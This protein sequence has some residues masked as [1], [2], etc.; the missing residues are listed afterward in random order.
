MASDKSQGRV[1]IVL[2]GSKKMANNTVLAEVLE[3][4]KQAH[5]EQADS[6]TRRQAKE[7][8]NTVFSVSEQGWSIATGLR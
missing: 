1:C 2:P 6:E 7:V 3:A 5:N 8:P 4:I